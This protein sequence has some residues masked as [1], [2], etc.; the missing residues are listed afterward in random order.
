ME[1]FFSR[2]GL[3]IVTERRYLEGFLGSKAA[4]DQFFGEKVYGWRDSVAT[5]AGLARRHPQTTYV[6]L[7]KS[8]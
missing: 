8:L 6:G 3:Q 4:R 1:A 5:L 2:Y 7:Q